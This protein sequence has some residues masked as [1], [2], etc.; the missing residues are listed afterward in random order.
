MAA[1]PAGRPGPFAPAQELNELCS[2]IIIEEQGTVD[3]YMGDCIMALW[4]A[5]ER[6][7]GHPMCAATA[8]IRCQ[9][10][11][12][13]LP[14]FRVRIGIQTGEVSAGNVG[15]KQKLNYT[16]LGDV[17]N[18][19]SRFEGL[20]KEYG[21]T[22]IAG[23]ATIARLDPERFAWRLLDTVCVKGKRKP[24]QVAAGGPCPCVRLRQSTCAS[25]CVSRV[26]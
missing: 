6:I 1:G 19:A 20:N 3:K 16:V 17:V 10:A 2:S 18:T 14:L 13:T 9:Y 25:D 24:K 12:G 26:R 8:A 5:P 22:I 4:N 21:T 11:V 15:S 7:A 23:E